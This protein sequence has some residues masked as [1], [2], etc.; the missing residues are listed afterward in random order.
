MLSNLVQAP[1]L[2]I[3]QNVET[4]CRYEEVQGADRPHLSR[5]RGNVDS[6]RDEP[7][8]PNRE[9]L[10]RRASDQQPEPFGRTYGYP[11]SYQRQ[12]PPC[13]PSY[14]SGNR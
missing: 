2:S 5:E 11:S 1:D 9:G 13:L 10:T 6:L 7:S 14:K 8:R 12:Q 3:V 4:A